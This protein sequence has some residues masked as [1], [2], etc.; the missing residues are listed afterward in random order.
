MV[1]G[2]TWLVRRC[3]LLLLMQPVR[4]YRCGVGKRENRVGD[5]VDSNACPARP[6]IAGRCLARARLRRVRSVDTGDAARTH[7]RD[8]GPARRGARA[9]GLAGSDATAEA[10]WAAVR[11]GDARR[12]PPAPAGHDRQAGP[13]S[14]HGAQGRDAGELSLVEGGARDQAQAL[15]DGVG[16]P[17]PAR[18]QGRDDLG[19]R[20]RPRRAAI[21]GDPAR[22]AAGAPSA[23]GAGRAP[24]AR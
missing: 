14:R 1:L 15:G 18:D 5:V 20:H 10:D 17:C 8:R 6:P 22:R 19:A 2:R 21:A 12:L 23:P 4:G 16:G 13:A 24:A 11:A 3:R 7:P 9:D